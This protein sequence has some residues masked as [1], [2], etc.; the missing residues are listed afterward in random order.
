MASIYWSYPALQDGDVQH[1]MIIDDAN[2]LYGY[3]RT[4]GSQTALIAL[5][6]DTLAHNATFSGLNAAPYNLPDG[7]QLVNALTGDLNTVYT[8]SGGSVTISAPSNW[9]VVLLEKSKI[10]TPAAVASLSSNTSGGTV[11]LTWSTVKTD[12][13]GK[14]ELV[15]GYE[16]HS[17][18]DASFTPTDGTRV[19]TVT[20]S[21]SPFPL[22]LQQCPVHLEWPGA[23]A[24]ECQLLQGLYRQCAGR[25]QPHGL[26]DR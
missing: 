3:G 5:N 21:D 9:G 13:A 2:K 16:I 1:G 6:R 18:P 11:T 12:T 19:A 22:R 26:S 23:A 15:T 25:H 10:D 4:N 7:T 14:R 20:P 17:G 8:V 24:A